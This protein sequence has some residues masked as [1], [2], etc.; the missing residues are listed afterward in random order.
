MRHTSLAVRFVVGMTY[1]AFGAVC[2]AATIQTL[3]ASSAVTSID[4]AA[5]FDVLTSSYAT[6]LD[7]YTENGLSITGGSSSWGTDPPSQ[8]LDP[9]HNGTVQGFYAMAYGSDTWVTIKT[10]DASPIFGAE[11]MYGN[12]W[13][14]GDSTFP[15]GNQK[16]LLQW[17][18]FKGG[19]MVYSGESVISGDGHNR[20]FLRSGSD[21]TSFGFA[22][23]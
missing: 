18:T 22:R 23:L 9:F 13:T 10:T 12:T 5:T 6:N 15:W 14:T 1:F 21:L 7:T 20:R 19:T 16:A 17:E 8:P 4:R 3:G 11:F 2:D